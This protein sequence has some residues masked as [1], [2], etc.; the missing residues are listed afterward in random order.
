MVSGTWNKSLSLGKGGG[1][2]WEP[3]MLGTESRK[4]FKPSN[5]LVCA[6]HGL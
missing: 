4:Y 2:F 1:T 5:H 3:P 6:P